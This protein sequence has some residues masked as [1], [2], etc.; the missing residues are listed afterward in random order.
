MS[1]SPFSSPCR[2]YNFDIPIIRYLNKKLGTNTWRQRADELQV[3]IF[4]F[5]TEMSVETIS[6]PESP[7]TTSQHLLLG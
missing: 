7:P 3:R 1:H 6:L 2:L 5:S 4:S